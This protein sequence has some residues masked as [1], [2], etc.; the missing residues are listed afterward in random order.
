M[1]KVTL[2][3]DE[4]VLAEL[5]PSRRSVIFPVLELVLI[6]GVV[7]MLIGLVDAYFLRL[8]ST[9]LGYELTPPSAVVP[10]VD[11]ALAPALVWARWALL[12]GWVVLVWRRCVRH[13]VFRHRSRMLLTNQRLI[14]ATGHLRSTIAQVP[15]HSVVDARTQGA[16]TVAVYVLGA[17]VPVVLRSVPH[18]KRFTRLL[19]EHAGAR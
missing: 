15:L 7:W 14:T 17:R 18:A 2:A 11:D 10:L 6:T 4:Y 13:L 19:R 5:S 9:Q 1:S 8:A 16:G 3:P 12:L